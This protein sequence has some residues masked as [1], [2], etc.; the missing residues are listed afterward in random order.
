MT[1]LEV[2]LDNL[3]IFGRLFARFSEIKASLVGRIKGEYA[4]INNL[5]SNFLKLFT[6]KQY[7]L[8][9]DSALNISTSLKAFTFNVSQQLSILKEESK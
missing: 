9:L 6:P 1:S 7:H 4:V 2:D 8:F 3:N 5:Q